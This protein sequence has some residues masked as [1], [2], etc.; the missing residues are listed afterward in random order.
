MGGQSPRGSLVAV[1]IVRPRWPRCSRVLPLPGN[2]WRWREI[3][4]RRSFRKVAA[5]AFRW[6]VSRSSTTAT[7]PIRPVAAALR[8]LAAEPARRRVAILGEMLELGDGGV[9]YHRQLAEHCS[10]IDRVVCV[11][12]GMTALWNELP[13]SQRWLQANRAADVPLQEIVASLAPGDV[14]L[15]KGSNRVFWADSRS[16]SQKRSQPAT[17]P[18]RRLLRLGGR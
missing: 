1:C 11:G 16:G 17:D 6:A 14:V 8:G 12:Q 5:H 9:E 10:G 3:F 4:R 15:V 13:A 7:T 2:R 18:G